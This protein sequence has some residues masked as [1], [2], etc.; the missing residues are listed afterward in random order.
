MKFTISLFILFFSLRSLSTTSNGHQCSQLFPNEQLSPANAAI[1]RIH[2]LFGGNL[3]LVLHGQND[4]G[5]VVDDN[6]L[7]PT[8]NAQLEIVIRTAAHDPE[9]GRI[10]TGRVLFIG[11]NAEDIVQVRN[12][13]W[14]ENELK[15]QHPHFFEIYENTIIRSI[16]EDAETLEITVSHPKR[17]NVGKPIQRLVIAKD[18]AGRP[19]A[20]RI[21]E[22]GF[23]GS[24]LNRWDVFQITPL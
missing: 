20:Y 1:E 5:A 11:N 2:D 3:T 4:S 7:H 14:N 15:S 24:L 12:M 22:A 9:V 21:E 6:L 17:S 19:Y 23:W 10:S 18:G 8:E 13:I 16:K